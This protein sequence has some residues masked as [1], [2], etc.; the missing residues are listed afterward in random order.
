MDLENRDIPQMILAFKQALRVTLTGSS[1]FALLAVLAGTACDNT[2]PVATSAPSDPP[3]TTAT[4]DTVAAADS[5][6]PAFSTSGIVGR[7][8]GAY[9]LLQAGVNPA[10]LILSHAGTSAS[11]I[12]SQIGAARTRG[13]RLMLVMTPGAHE[14]Y[15]SDRNGGTCQTYESDVNA[16]AFDFNRWKRV[17]ETYNTTTIKSAIAKAVSDGIVTGATVMD[18][19]NVCG[20]GPANTWGPCGTMTKAKVDQLCS[21]VK[22]IFTTLPA[23]PAHHHTDFEPSKSYKVCDFIVDQYGANQGSVTTFRD[24]ALAMGTRDHH[25]IFFSLSVL[26]GGLRDTDGTY[27]CTGPGQGGIGTHGNLCRMTATQVRTFG[28]TLGPVGC[29]LLMWHYDDKFWGRSDN[30]QAFQDVA[31]K[32]KSI[33]PRACRRS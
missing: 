2:D 5:L 3:V 33:S 7:S 25:A 9:R 18:E 32:M 21:L 29:G 15:M 1:V 10:P 22:Q 23:G 4:T 11:T 19:P 20:L 24:G 27:N 16:C 6:A 30:Q 26:D 28:L 13:L 14:L 8:F 31:A 17:M 12:V